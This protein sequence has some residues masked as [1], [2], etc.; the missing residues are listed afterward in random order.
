MAVALL[1]LRG[2]GFV[3]GVVVWRPR[4]GVGDGV[5]ACVAWLVI[6]QRPYEGRTSPWPVSPRIVAARP[7]GLWV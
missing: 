7:W 5:E 6:F 1:W 2:T 4:D 3:G